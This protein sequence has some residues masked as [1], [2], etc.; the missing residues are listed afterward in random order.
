MSKQWR[1]NGWDST[2]Q[3]F[4]AYY[5]LSAFSQNQMEMLLQRFVCRDLTYDEIA[6]CSRR[7]LPKKRSFRLEV[8]IDVSVRFTMSAGSNP[9]YN[10]TVVETER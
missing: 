7:Q 3:I 10:A 6:E 4:E 2:T 5:P 8:S 1:V 9:H